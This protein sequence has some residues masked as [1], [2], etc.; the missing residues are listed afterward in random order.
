MCTYIWALNIVQL[1]LHLHTN[2]FPIGSVCPS[3]Y[4][5]QESGHYQSPNLLSPA[6]LF[7]HISPYPLLVIRTPVSLYLLFVVETRSLAHYACHGGPNSSC[8]DFC[9][10]CIIVPI[11]KFPMHPF[12]LF[13]ILSPNSM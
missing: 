6:K 9:L 12:V 4:L 2:A 3:S 10:F 7:S 13:I 11:Q 8:Q 1:G 5:S